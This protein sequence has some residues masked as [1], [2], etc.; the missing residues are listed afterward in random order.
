MKMSKFILSAFADEINTN[1]KIQMDVLEQHG[2]NFIEMRGVNGK[3]LVEHSLD[4]VRE[5]K[6]EL[7]KRGFKISAIGSPIGKI[8]ITDEFGPHLELFKHT[9]EIAKILD[10]KFIR[11]FS[12]FIPEGEE[13]GKYRSEVMHRWNE[14]IKAA[15]G[16]GLVLL[17]ENEKAIYG[18]TPERCLDLIKTM[19]C[20]YLKAIFDTANFIQ[21]DVEPYPKAFQLL[22]ENVVYFHIKDA[23]FKDH[24]ITPAGE[25]DG[26]IKE[27]LEELHFNGFEGFLSIEPHLA[28]FEGLQNL[29][30]NAKIAVEF[31]GA[32]DKKFAVAVTALKKILEEI[33]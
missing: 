27:M 20:N 16:S 29:R 30:Q 26:K 7:D 3:G 23:V 14:F 12:F 2:I 13:P 17:H 6:K 33:I 8:K 19:N 15:E 18:D 1:L 31:P 32:E 9:I 11:M 24:H 25:G 4:E 5:I 21:C 22:K 28:S 10:S